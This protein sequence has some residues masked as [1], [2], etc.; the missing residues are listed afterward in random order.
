MAN[1]ADIADDIINVIRNVVTQYPA[2]S[3]HELE[4]NVEVPLSVRLWRVSGCHELFASLGFD[5]MEVGQDKVTLRT[6]KQANRRNCQFVLQAL[7]ALFDTNEAPKSLGIDSASSCE[8]LYDDGRPEKRSSSLSPI[9]DIASNSRSISPAGT[10]KSLN[11]NVKMARPSLPVPRQP[12]LGLGSAFTSY[13]RK[14]RGEPDGGHTD[15]DTNMPLSSALTNIELNTDSD[16]SDGFGY[17]P[18][19]VNRFDGKQTKMSYPSGRVQLKVRRPGGNESD[20]A[21]TP[22]PPI[23]FH[24]AESNVSLALAH[25]T[26]IRNLYSMHSHMS[27]NEPHAQG[28]QRTDDSSSSTSSTTDWDGS[29]HATVLRRTHLHNP[30]VVGPPLPLPRQTHPLMADGLRAKMHLPQTYNNLNGKLKGMHSLAN[31]IESSDSEFE[32]IYETCA[33]RKPGQQMAQQQ[34]AMQN[35]PELMDRLSV[36]TEHTNN[37]GSIAGPRKPAQIPDDHQ[38]AAA[39]APFKFGAGGGGGGQYSAASDAD[40]LEPQH[41][42]ISLTLR[43][44]SAKEINKPNLSSH[45]KNIQDLILRKINREMTPT[46]SDVYHERNMDLGLAPPL[47]KL[48]LSKNYEDGDTKPTPLHKANSSETVSDI[49]LS[50]SLAR[51]VATDA[52]ADERCDVCQQPDASCQCDSKSTTFMAKPWMNNLNGSIIAQLKKNDFDAGAVDRPAKSAI[53]P[54]A[55]PESESANIVAS[56][57][58]SSNNTQTTIKRDISP[59]SELLR[60]DEG[61]GRSVADSQCSGNYKS[62]DLNA[63]KKLSQVQQRIHK[64]NMNASK[65]N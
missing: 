63:N 9:A 40:V 55:P 3:T 54:T 16:I 25:Q 20:A 52:S 13:V 65:Q 7:L 18:H 14:R 62:I 23:T 45:N 4:P 64:F 33:E 1:H 28:V 51:Y 2:K 53:I 15:M 5:L 57:S 37:I 10:V 41:K 30:T 34:Y 31:A 27:L 47:S 11:L 29:G 43:A 12:M 48:L 44:N 56:D 26:R 46:I 22:S 50:T 61:D 39:A 32:R 35:M 21:F 8:S 49:A 58:N 42:D 6:G 24:G 38:S 17:A 36:R 19:A 60:R 59:Y